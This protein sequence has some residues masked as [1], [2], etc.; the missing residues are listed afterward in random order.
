MEA[1]RPCYLVRGGNLTTV[2]PD[3][4]AEVDAIEMQPDILTCVTCRKMKVGSIPPRRAKGTVFGHREIRKVCTNGISAAWNISEILTNKGFRIDFVF[5]ERSH[6]R[7]RYGS[8]KPLRRLKLVPRK[9]IALF[10]DLSGRL[11]PPVFP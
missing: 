5:Y 6:N 7:G 4:C 1:E 9:S 8:G 2:E 11:Y 3:V 10:F